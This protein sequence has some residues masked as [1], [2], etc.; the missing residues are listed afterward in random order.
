MK[1]V[2]LRSQLQ[3][4]PSFM[5]SLEAQCQSKES[6]SSIK[7]GRR[8]CYKHVLCGVVETNPRPIYTYR[9]CD[10]DVNVYIWLEVCSTVNCNVSTTVKPLYNKPPLDH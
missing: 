2:A 10:T 7:F 6:Y 8:E 4:C 1:R 9:I 3:K 5:I